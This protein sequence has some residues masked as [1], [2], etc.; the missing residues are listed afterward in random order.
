MNAKFQHSYPT[1][2]LRRDGISII[3]VLT[4][5]VVAAIGVS[6]VLILIPFAVKQSQLGI[7][8]DIADLV[9]VNATEDLQLRGFTIVDDSGDLPWTG[10]MVGTTIIDQNT[11]DERHIASGEGIITTLPIE[12]AITPQ[13][14]HLDPYSLAASMQRRIDDGLAANFGFPVSAGE[15]NP[16]ILTRYLPAALKIPVMTLVRRGPVG[17]VLGLTESQMLVQGSDDLVFGQTDFRGI[18]A[19]EL[20]GP[21]PYFTLSDAGSPV[22]RQYLGRVSWSAVMMPEKATGAMSRPIIDPASGSLINTT[23]PASRYR[24]HVLTYAERSVQELNRLTEPD[25]DNLNDMFAATVA[26]Y[27]F[28]PATSGDR[29]SSP[30]PNNLNGGFVSAVNRIVLNNAQIV[31]VVKDDWVMLINNMLP[32]NV[33]FR[34]NGT[35]PPLPPIPERFISDGTVNYQF[36]VEEAGYDQQITFCRVT[37]VDVGVDL[38][39]DGDYVDANERRPSLSVE[40][41]PFNFYYEGLEANPALLPAVPDP[42]YTSQT[43]VVHLKDVINVY[44]RTI[45]L[46]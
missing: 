23:T 37:S 39:E 8:R 27:P 31:G 36:E 26:R 33:L 6:G 17:G 29:D 35:D 1:R 25:A 42:A 18:E 34:P 24:V 20:A 28:A 5:L 10:G 4:S 46:E 41:G 22:A 3:E 40:G 13:V 30:N 14:V 19:D 43:W 2:R 12:N 45:T 9:G 21:Q 11:A 32:R 38:N 44:E 7:E 16:D 15:S